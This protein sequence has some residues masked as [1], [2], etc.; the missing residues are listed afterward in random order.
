MAGYEL[1]VSP[2]YSTVT[3]S[4]APFL[5]VLAVYMMNNAHIWK[6][7]P[8]LDGTLSWKKSDGPPEAKKKSES[9]IYGPAEEGL[10]YEL[11]AGIIDKSL[12]LEQVVQEEILEETGYDVPLDKIEY[13]TMYNSSVG[14][15]GTKQWLYFA[16]VTDDMQT[17]KGG[18]S[19]EDHEM[20][21][22]VYIPLEESER[23]VFDTTKPKTTGLC[24]SFF[25]F[26]QYKKPY[27]NRIN[28]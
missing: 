8:V 15:S 19:E 21:E 11:C 3:H 25:W 4:D 28:K 2:M 5:V 10:T 14:V 6:D 7:H 16:E 24:F 27:L 1:V 9:D 12:K 13:V 22:V 17:G 23:F 20:I 26:N 18:G